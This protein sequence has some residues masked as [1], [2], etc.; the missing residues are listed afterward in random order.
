MINARLDEGTNIC[1][2]CI[3]QFHGYTFNLDAFLLSIIRSFLTSQCNEGAT[4][5][6]ETSVRICWNS[7]RYGTKIHCENTTGK[8]DPRNVQRL[9]KPRHQF[10]R[11][12]VAIFNS[13]C[14]RTCTVGRGKRKG[15]AR[16]RAS[17]A[18][19]SVDVTSQGCRAC[20]DVSTDNAK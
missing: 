20:F 18:L 19:H 7:F 16:Q 6:A 10:A 4:E 3:V 8:V 15:T 14:G 5:I 11:K 17:L 9:R 13:S 12:R 2:R 1:V